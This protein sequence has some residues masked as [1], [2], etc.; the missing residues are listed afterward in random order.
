MRFSIIT[1]VNVWNDYRAKSLLRAI[2]S[3]E[4]QTFKDF[5]LIVVNDGST[6]KF[7]VPS[8]PWLKVINK[9]HEERVIAFNAGLEWASG[10]IIC[11]LDSD[12][13]YNPDYLEKVNHYFA[14]YKHYKMFNFGSIMI[15]GDQG[16]TQRDAFNPKKKK[17]GHEVF[18]G[19]NIVNG[20][21]VFHRSI[22][23]E[24]GGF[25]PA[26]IK[27]VDCTALNYGGV[28]DLYMWTPYDFSAAAQLEFPEMREFFM[29]NHV[30]EPEKII[31]ELGNPWGND[32]YLFFKYTR[33]YHS[34]PMPD[35]LLTVHIKGGIE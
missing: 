5:E 16:L 28:R 14:N 10:E 3:V 15:W 17:V 24:L 1:P 19:G 31:K 27:D 20:T 8:F 6:A 23:E 2:K 18:G 9:Q 35:H 34:K 29:V 32:Y 4:N 12:D 30:D 13:E 7:E 26:V 33:K 22:Y 21:F 11:F 25:P